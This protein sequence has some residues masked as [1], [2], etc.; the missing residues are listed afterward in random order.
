MADYDYE[1]DVETIH[2]SGARVAARLCNFV[3]A[4]AYFAF[5]TQQLAKSECCAYHPFAKKLLG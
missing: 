3:E 4:K 2:G 1:V 5:G